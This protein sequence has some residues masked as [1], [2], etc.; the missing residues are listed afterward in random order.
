MPFHHRFR[1]RDNLLTGE[2][3]KKSK[4]NLQIFRSCNSFLILYFLLSFDIH[5]TFTDLDSPWLVAQTASNATSSLMLSTESFFASYANNSSSVL[6]APSFLCLSSPLLPLTTFILEVQRVC[7]WDVIMCIAS[8][9]LEGGD[10]FFGWDLCILN[11]CSEKLAG[12]GVGF[13]LVLTRNTKDQLG[14]NF[15]CCNV[16]PMQA[17][18]LQQTQVLDTLRL[19]VRKSF[20]FKSRMQRRQNN[21][22]QCKWNIKVGEQELPSVKGSILYKLSA[23]S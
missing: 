7:I 4:K 1:N 23:C 12:L 10:G 20:I 13:G 21:E 17:P 18:I 9:K 15:F 2:G 11:D 22:E 8:I 16:R 3:K 14:Q 6:P 5:W 19:R